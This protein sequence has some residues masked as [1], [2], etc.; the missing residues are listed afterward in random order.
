MISKDIAI[1]DLYTIAYINQHTADISPV[2]LIMSSVL[3][4][5]DAITTMDAIIGNIEYTF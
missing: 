1:Y 5:N 3:V 4:I 2:A